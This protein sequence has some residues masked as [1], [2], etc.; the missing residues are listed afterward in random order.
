MP[1]GARVRILTVHACLTG[2]AWPH[3]DVIEDVRVVVLWDRC[4]V[5]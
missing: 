5:W 3:Y 2:A 4:A 1:V